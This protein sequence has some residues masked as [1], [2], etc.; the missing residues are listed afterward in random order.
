MTC[1]ATRTFML[2]LR[3]GIIVQ[4]SECL[5]IISSSV[6]NLSPSYFLQIFSSSNN[7]ALPSKVTEKAFFDIPL[8]ENK[9]SSHDT[10]FSSGYIRNHIGNLYLFNRIHPFL[11]SL[12]IPMIHQSCRIFLSSLVIVLPSNPSSE[13]VQQPFSSTPPSQHHR[14]LFGCSL[15]IS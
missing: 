8:T 15:V 13:A 6:G 10:M 11:S 3:N 4:N 12:Y 1:S 7:S 2:S 5:D 9:A 14:F